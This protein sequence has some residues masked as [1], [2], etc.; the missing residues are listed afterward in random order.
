TS[1]VNIGDGIGRAL[2]SHLQ[3]S[4]WQWLSSQV[5]RIAVDPDS[6]LVARVFTSLLRELKSDN[7]PSLVSL[8]E[9]L[10]CAQGLPL[11][12]QGWTTVRL[13]RV[14]VLACIP[15]LDEAAYTQLIERLFKYG[16]MEELVALY[17][18]L[19]VYHY[20]EA[21]QLRCKEG[22]RSNIGTVRHAVM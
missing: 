12:V 17:S 2:K 19:P 7:K 15:K 21:W 20:P 6:G 16:D 10:K 8:N 9:A 22:L 1:D 18:A 3:P 4:A 14:W 11:T 5:E 13:A